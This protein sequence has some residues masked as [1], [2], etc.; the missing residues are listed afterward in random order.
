MFTSHNLS[1]KYILTAGFLFTSVLGT[2]S[3]FFYEW[4]GRSMLAGLFCPISESVWEH[5]KLLFFPALLFCLLV[6]FLCKNI[7]PNMTLPV[8]SGILTGSTFIPVFFYTYSGILGFTVVW[9]DIAIFYLCTGITFTMAAKLYSSQK[10]GRFRF[11]IYGLTILYAILFFLFTFIR[12]NL[13]LFQS[14]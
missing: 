9:L 6:K 8:L 14:P 1:A 4:S 11:L 3:H 12:P 10:T 13:S 5:M 2:L 7:V